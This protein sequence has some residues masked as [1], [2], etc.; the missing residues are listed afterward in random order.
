[1]PYLDRARAN[2]E[3]ALDEACKSLPHGGDHAVRAFIA[4]RLADAVQAGLT[5]IGELRIV[6]RK[7]LAEYRTG[8]SGTAR[9]HARMVD[10]DR[11]DQSD[12]DEQ[13]R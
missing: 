8:R 12:E 11:V 2:M 9:T 4:H 1:V 6:A 3:A 10:L 7:A 5:A 13:R